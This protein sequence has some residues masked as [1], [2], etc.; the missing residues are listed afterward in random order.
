MKIYKLNYFK[1]KKFVDNYGESI[2]YLHLLQCSSQHSIN[3]QHCDYCNRDGIVKTKRN[4][5]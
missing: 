1:N 4:Q 3:M 2:R 5:N